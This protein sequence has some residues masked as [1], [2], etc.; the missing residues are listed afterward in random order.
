MTFCLLSVRD[1]VFLIALEVT[2]DEASNKLDG[3]L[4]LKVIIIIVAVSAAFLGILIIA[5]VTLSAVHFFKKYV[6]LHSLGL[7][8]VYAPS[9]G[10]IQE[11]LY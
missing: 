10:E 2:P 1:C 8:L 6:L 7:Y 11:H 3:D 9:F 5:G 4:L